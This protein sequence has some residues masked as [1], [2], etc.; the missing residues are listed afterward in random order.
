MH[1]L[2]LGTCMGAAATLVVGVACANEELIKLS[3]DPS[4]GHAG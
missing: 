2:L 1:K 3:Q 4:D